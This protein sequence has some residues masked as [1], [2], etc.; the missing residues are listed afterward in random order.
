MASV[1]LAYIDKTDCGIDGVDGGW[2]W[3]CQWWGENL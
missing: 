1:S 2:H 3:D